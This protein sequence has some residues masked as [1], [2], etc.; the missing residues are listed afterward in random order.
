MSPFSRQRATVAVLGAALVLPVAWYLLSTE[1]S[2]A[3][4]V[5]AREE[6]GASPVRSSP[7]A[8]F[9]TALPVALAAADSAAHVIGSQWQSAA[10]PEFAAFSAWSGR[11]LAAPVAE[12]AAMLPE[13]I[14]AA[15][16]RRALLVKMIRENPEQ[17]LAAAVPV[18]VRKDLPQAITALLEERVSGQGSIEMLSATP[19]AGQTT[20]INPS[21][22]HALVGRTEYEAFPY[23]RRAALN[24]LPDVS[25]LGIALDGSLAVSDSPVRVL[26]AGEQADGREVISTCPVS[27]IET[28]LAGNEPLNTEAVTAV[29]TQGRIR[30]VCQTSHVSTLERQLISG[31]GLQ[32]NGLPGSSAVSGKPSYAHTHGTKKVLI[33]RVDFTDVPGT[34]VN[35]FENTDT[36]TPEIAVGRFND[37]GGLK[38]YYEQVSYGQTSLSVA[39]LVA[40]VS[41]DVTPVLRMPA[42]A[43]SYVTAGAAGVG[44]ATLMHADAQTLATAAGY[45]M[46]NYDRIGLVYTFLGDLPGSKMSFGGLGSTPG[47]NFWTNGSYDFSIIAHEVG[48]TYGLNHSSSWLVTDDNPVSPAGDLVEYGDTSDIM[49]DGGLI[50][51]EFNH[52]NKSIAQWLPDAAVT[53]I[54]IGGTYRVYRFDH[55]GANLANQLALKVVRNRTQDYW[56]GYRRATDNSNFDNGAYVVWGAN[57]NTNGLLLDF[58]TP[59]DDVG[60]APLAVGQSFNDTASGITLTTVAQGGSGADEYLDVQVAFQPRVAWTQ[61]GYSVDEQAGTASLTLTRSNNSAGAVSVHWATAPGTATSPAD[62]S[63]SSG[64]VTWANGDG[65][66]KIITIPITADST[67]EGPQDFTVTLSAPSGGT[68]VDDPAATVSIVEGGTN[69]GSFALKFIDSVVRKVLVQP[70]GKLLIAGPFTEVENTTRV[71]IA[72]MTAA[73]DMD[74]SFAAGGADLDREVNDIARQ[75]DGKILVVGDFDHMMGVAR[76]KVARLNADGTIDPGF[77]PGAGPDGAVYAVLVQPDGKVLI[78]GGFTS[79]AGSAREYVARLNADG[80]LDSSFTGPNFGSTGGWQVLALALQADGKLLIG[81]DIYF[82]GSSFKSGICRVTTSGALDPAFDG[83]THGA[84]LLDDPGSPYGVRSIAVQLDGKILIAGSFTAFNSVARGGFAR[85]TATGALD[86]GFPATSGGTC[87]TIMVQPDGKIVV[88]GDFGDFNGVEVY[89]LVRLNSSGVVDIPFSAAGS[90]NAAVNC[91]AMQADGKIVFGCDYANFQNVVDPEPIWRVFG[92]LPGLPGTLQLSSPTVSTPE[93]GSVTLSVTRTGGSSGALSVN[94]A[95]VPGSADAS[96]FTPVSG[97]LSWASGDTVVKNITIP[98]TTDALDDLG[99]TFTV[100]LGQP[101]RGGAILGSTQ[102][103]LVTIGAPA[104]ITAYQT[105]KNAKFTPEERESIGISGDDSDPDSDG[106]VN[107]L[108]FAFNLAPKTASLTGI[109]TGALQNIGGSDYLTLSFRRQLAAPELTYIPQVNLDLPGTWLENAILVGTPVSNGD[110]TET[111][112]YRSST[113]KTASEHGFMRL[114]VTLAT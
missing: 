74:T 38:D 82:S 75:P 109:P 25:I 96:D 48:H 55:P 26:E 71:G 45:N 88:G 5:S 46:A 35:G 91:L 84:H 17:A 94:Y 50:T 89:N 40:G 97:T 15:T 24:Y 21:S 32:A 36:I 110:G 65:S 83:V 93:G 98:I 47:K 34:P 11:Y 42:T 104:P 1:S 28:S 53:T 59:G 7:P 8:K 43:S 22:R 73:G 85:L 16:A 62:F 4:A 106:I 54:N 102:A 101:L 113:P 78:G 13:G 49:G 9:R 66:D 29:E 72:R 103:S 81:G 90:P 14:A 99:E 33:I 87:N 61:S 114:K 27:G 105:W 112:T 92:G 108:E 111:V 23:G 100:N 79:Y 70:D 41:P 6:I 2:R 56:I 20:F 37:A 44:N 12:R 30:V 60:D 77:D 64:D 57:R 52:W 63:T 69:D 68:I 67:P 95:T 76:N 18:M 10:Q 58:N 39:P 86:T 3:P 80:S 31:E 19:V 107:L 51:N